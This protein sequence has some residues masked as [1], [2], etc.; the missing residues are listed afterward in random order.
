MSYSVVARVVAI[1]PHPNPEITRLELV[2]LNC[3]NDYNETDAVLVT[4]KHYRVGQ[5]GIWVRPG[6][7]IPGWLAME[8]W[9]VGKKRSNSWFEVREI[10]IR[11]TAS[12]GLF[13]GQVYMKDGSAE[14]EQRFVEAISHGGKQLPEESPDWIS[15]PYWRPEWKTGDVLDDYLGIVSTRPSSS[16]A[17][18]LL[19]KQEV[20]GEADHGEARPSGSI[21]ATGST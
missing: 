4:G 5:L 20:A 21:P 13:C 7:W 10:E 3:V 1:E 11:G 15:W 9:L 17:E 12:P 16:V 14:S 19:V 8:L 6:A 18:H 2:R